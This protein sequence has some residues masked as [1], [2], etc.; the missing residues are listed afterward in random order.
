MRLPSPPDSILMYHRV[1][2]MRFDPHALC[3]SPEHFAQHLEELRRSSE[4]RSL[5]DILRRRRCHRPSVAVTFDDGYADNL[6]IAL[7]MLER[8][9]VP[10]TV[11]LASDAIGSF[12]GFW[13]DRLASL[14]DGVT[15]VDAS[16]EVGGR[17]LRILLRG[18]EAAAQTVRILQRRWRQ[19]D[20]Q[21]IEE[22][23]ESLAASLGTNVPDVSSTAGTLT[24]S[25]ARTLGAHPLCTVGAHTTDHRQLRG[26]SFDEQLGTIR[27]S[28]RVLEELL[29]RPILHFAYPFGDWKSFDRA[30]VRAVKAAGLESAVTTEPGGV[31]GLN[32]RFYL[33]RRSIRD[34]SAEAFRCQLARWTARGDG[35]AHSRRTAQRAS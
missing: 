5:D 17:P 25:Q 3:V 1:A 2:S 34:W 7:P 4:V 27:D 29:L 10:F 33:P 18:P 14:L 31:T 35:P 24:R 19:Y 12:R 6:E 21:E 23:L 16:L 8:F 15:V 28:S 9:E 22:M 30:S 11:F 20:P 26:R 32:S 13:W